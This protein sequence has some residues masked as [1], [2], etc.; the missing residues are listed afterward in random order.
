MRMLFLNQKGGV[1]KTTLVLL[2]S[3]VLKKA[4][5]D[6]AIDDRDPQGSAKFFAK[7]FGVP[8]LSENPNAEYV[9]ID[10]PGHLRIEG[11]VEREITNLIETSDKLI[12]VTD[13]SPA[14][15][16]GTAPM[17]RLILEKKRP[18]AKAS[19]LFNKVRSQTTMGKQSN[20]DIASELGL[21]ALENELTLSASFENAFVTGLAAVTGKHRE[22]IFRLALEVMK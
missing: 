10:T 4:G 1:G 11:E 6:V 5:Y 2:M 19:L 12:I 3:G 18:E 22:E 15:I 20:Q 14:T 16:H 17:V 8:L 7:N 21:P 9:V 13:K